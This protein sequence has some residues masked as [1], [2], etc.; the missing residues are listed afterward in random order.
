MHYVVAAPI[1]ILAMASAVSPPVPSADRELVL[2]GVDMVLVAGGALVLAVWAVRWSRRGRSDPLVAAADRHHSLVPELLAIPLLIYLGASLLLQVGLS[3][4]TPDEPLSLATTMNLGNAVQLAG[5]L[6]CL[7]V[8]HRFFG[9]GLPTF[10]WGRCRFVQALS[11]A[12]WMVLVALFVCTG[13]LLITTLL[14]PLL[15]PEY[16]F[17]QHDTLQALATESTSLGAKIALCAGAVVIAPIAEE[18]F[19]RGLLQTVLSNLLGSR[20]WAIGLTAVIFAFMHSAQPHAVPPLAAL[21]IL[22]GYA[23]ERHGSL[24]VPILLH[25]GF[26]LRTIIWQLLLD[27][28]AG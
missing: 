22:L 6:A 19:F 28:A 15:R 20:W 14:L 11:S 18:C 5:L 1:C 27:P 21:A 23:Y 24:L 2:L 12:G 13:V 26:N 3:A 8:G 16:E 17:P 25:M 4:S 9:G 7:W 10:L